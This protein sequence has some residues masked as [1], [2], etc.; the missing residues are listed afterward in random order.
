MYS[1]WNK[2]GKEINLIDKN[3]FLLSVK[4]LLGVWQ[5]VCQVWLCALGIREN[6]LKEKERSSDPIQKPEAKPTDF[7]N[8]I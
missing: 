5:D 3:H 1:D 2:K 4:L 7:E 6:T 8:P